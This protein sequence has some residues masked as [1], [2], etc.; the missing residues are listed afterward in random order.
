MQTE[1]TPDMHNA[2]HTTSSSPVPGS[3]I[4]RKLYGS[5]GLPQ[6]SHVNTEACEDPVFAATI[7]QL[8]DQQPEIIRNAIRSADAEGCKVVLYAADRHG[9]AFPVELLVSWDDV[10]TSL[11]MRSFLGEEPQASADEAAWQIVLEDAFAW[12]RVMTMPRGSTAAQCRAALGRP[13]RAEEVLF[14]LTGRCNR[15]AIGLE[16]P[17]HT[18]AVRS[19]QPRASAQ[20]FARS[21]KAEPAQPRLTRTLH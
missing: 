17:T 15:Q 11:A 5:R 18:P 20:T 6:S 14:A 7:G 4:S 21:N 2:T 19:A 10:S 8:A 12:L 16:A 13:C 1:R 3:D 9:R